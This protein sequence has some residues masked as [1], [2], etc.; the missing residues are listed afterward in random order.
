MF[1]LLQNLNILLSSAILL[2]KDSVSVVCPDCDNPCCSRVQHLF[3]EKD[4]IYLKLSGQKVNLRKRFKNRKG[5][6]FLSDK[7]C[8]L[9][10]ETRPFACHRYICPKIE[11]EMTRHDPLSIQK[12][13][14][15]FKIID[16]LRSRLWKEYLESGLASRHMEKSKSPHR[17]I[18]SVSRWPQSPFN[19]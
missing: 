19:K 10:P 15:K 13:N 14:H 5:C 6:R 16:D 12:L 2:Q 1:E 8:I 18:G 9:K 3:D 7:G 11:R 4:I 17:A